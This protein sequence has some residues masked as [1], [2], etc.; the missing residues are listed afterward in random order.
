MAT[1]EETI[2]EVALMVG[3]PG[4]NQLTR[5]NYLRLIRRA[6]RD[7]RNKGWYIHHEDDESLTVLANT[8]SYAIPL[9]FAYIE[10][11]MMSDTINNTTVFLDPISNEHWEPRLNGGVPVLEFL[12]S[13]SLFTGRSLKLIGQKRPTLYV[14]TAQDIDAGMESFIAERAAFYAFRIMGMG[15]SELARTRQQDANQALALSEDFLRSHPQE[16]RMAPNARY[17]PGR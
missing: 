3:D 6:S 9:P 4:L 14:N 16:F 13:T 12:T 2:Q 15:G 8:W 5:D 1:V 11:I 7:A 17:V 10:R